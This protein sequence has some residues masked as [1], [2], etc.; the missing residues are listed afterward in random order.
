MSCKNSTVFIQKNSNKSIFMKRLL[1]LS[2][3]VILFNATS[4]SQNSTAVIAKSSKSKKAAN[5]TVEPIQTQDEKNIQAMSKTVQGQNNLRLGLPANATQDEYQIAKE[6][7]LNEN[8]EK[9]KEIFHRQNSESSTDIREV[10]RTI[11][12][13]MSTEQ[14]ARIHAHPELFIIVD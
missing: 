7:L 2:G 12:N 9:Y 1:L 5:S 8:P 14:K 6:N 13:N 3:L 10:K 11:Y 4:F